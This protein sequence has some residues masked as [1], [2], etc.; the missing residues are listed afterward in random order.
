[1]DACTTSLME[2]ASESLTPTEQRIAALWCEELAVTTPVQPEDNFFS[3]GGDS[4]AMMMVIYRIE[5]IF[6]VELSPV[7]LLEAPE[8]RQFCVRVDESV[9]QASETSSP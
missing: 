1:M 8:L 4:V 6:S 2:P 3:L 7:T 5:E 9:L